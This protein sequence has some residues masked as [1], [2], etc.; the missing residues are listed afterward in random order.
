M[1]T[2]PKPSRKAYLPQKE[3]QG[4][5]REANTSF[6]QS[7]QWRRVRKLYLQSHPLCVECAAAGRVTPARVVDHIR[8]INDGG[9][10][11]AFANLQGL[12]DSCHN[13]KSGR[14]AHNR[15]SNE[16]K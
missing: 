13:K 5:R 14:E 10:P 2:I 3:V 8:R 9:A 12:C 6:Y 1:P 4:R 16:G 7:Q 11:F 15:N